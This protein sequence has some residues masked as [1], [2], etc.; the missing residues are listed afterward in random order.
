[1]RSPSQSVTGMLSLAGLAGLLSRAKLIVSN[2]SG[3]FHLASA[4]GTPTVGLFWCGNVPAYGPA[5][6]RQTAIHVSWRMDCPVC[7][8]HCM[9]PGC[10]HQ[11]SF[12]SEIPVEEVITSAIELFKQED[13]RE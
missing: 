7:G 11:D 3:P 13:V 6:T 4:V 9:Q 10:S 2:D 5:R 12:V 1:M 8:E